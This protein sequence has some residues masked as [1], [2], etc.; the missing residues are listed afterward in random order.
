MA[1]AAEKKL[2]PAM[3]QYHRFKKQHPGCVLFFRMGDFFEMFFE[4][5]ELAHR[6]L[7]V[8][9]TQRTEGVPMAGVP[10][11]AVEGYLR[12]MIQA[13]HRVAVCDQ[14]EDA[15]EAKGVVER[16]VTRVVTP[17]TLTDD[18]L[19]EEDRENPLCAVVWVGSGVPSSGSRQSAAAGPGPRNPEPA[20]VAVA[21]AE[22]STGRFRCALWPEA[23]LADELARIAPGEVLYCETATGDPPD[24]VTALAERLGVAVTPRPAWHFR[25]AEAV[26]ALQRQ[27]GVAQL[28]GFGF[29][30]DEPE[31]AACGAVVAYLRETQK[32]SGGGG[33]G[34]ASKRRSEDGYEVS[35]GLTHLEPPKRFERADHLVID[36]TSLRALEVTQTIRDGSTE[37]SLLGVLQRG[38]ASGG[39]SGGASGG[40]GCVTAMGKRLL[41]QWLCYPLT[42][43]DAVR[44]RHRVVEAVVHDARLRDGL[45]SALAKVQDVERLSGRIAIGRASPRDLVAL[46]KSVGGVSELAGLLAD[47][48]STAA[49]HERAVAV[50]EPLTALAEQVRIACVDDPPGHL[51]AGGLIADGYDA[52]LDESR[53]LQRDANQWLA[54]YQKRLT[55]ETDIGSLKVG[56]NKVFG[57]YIEVTAAN[58][59]K[60][61]DND[62][63][64]R[65]WT[66]KQTLKNA[67]RYITPQLK[68][69]E[70]KVLTAEQRAVAREQALF[71]RLCDAASAR[72]EP[73]RAFAAI[74]AE[75]DVLRCFAERAARKGYVKPEL[76]DEPLL[77]IEGGR[78]PVLDELLGE[79]C[80]PNHF[81]LG[82]GDPGSGVRRDGGAAPGTRHPEPDAASLALITGPNMSGKSTY[83]RTAALITLLAHTGSFV[84]A[85]RAVVGRAD[86]IFT[87]IGASDELHAG[88]STFMV[89]MTEAANL[90]HHA[91]PHSLV[92]LDEIGR[93]TSTLDGL[94]LAWAIAEYLAGGAAEAASSGER[95]V[96]SAETAG[97]AGQ[98]ASRDLSAAR[99]AS[100]A[101]RTLFATHYHELTQLADRLPGVK[102]LHVTVR[103]WRDEIV[104]LHRIVPGATSQSYGIHVAKIAGMPPAVVDR[105]SRLLRELAVSHEGSVRPS[106]PAARMDPAP[107]MP[108]FASADPHPMVEAMREVKLE[109][110]SP[111]EAF[112]ELRR[113]HAMLK[114]DDAKS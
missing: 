73:I 88:Q 107:Q 39:G 102:N 8:T 81:A 63:Y 64:F 4:D 11:H 87:R 99:A 67:E 31:L 2:T 28:S 94:A 44:G 30:G 101:P 74:V 15:S 109:S 66:R 41:R 72:L 14:V 61:K 19:L 78:H 110:L 23:D 5:A 18:A 40:G 83:I 46:G 103:E 69:F 7:G 95:A 25:Q 42:D 68:E 56:F 105:A 50:A 55:E 80:V 75:L 70:G 91:T 92:I 79:R 90:C 1:D 13:G 6:V 21:W 82:V 106:P 62:D 16:D 45:R 54:A 35:A 86:R 37:R 33:G 89:E 60:V 108:L 65:A 98:G 27:Y 111:L 104:F 20:S 24:R 113:L 12:R 85:D 76:T 100:A 51:R 93:G 9:L 112:D 77:Q 96:E 57:Y 10:Y 36:Q 114:E 29:E 53:S 58:K 43:L 97:P 59:H 49:H 34:G 22:L 32:I 3:R 84:P 71:A 52:Q 17:G 48:E 47:R 26:E 38:G